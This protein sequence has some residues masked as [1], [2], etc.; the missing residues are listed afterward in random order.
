[1]VMEAGNH[2]R[3]SG[4]RT[5]MRD[6]WKKARDLKVLPGSRF[7]A[8]NVPYLLWPDLLA[9]FGVDYEYHTAEGEIIGNLRGILIEGQVDEA[10]SPGRYA[11]FW[12]DSRDLPRE[13]RSADWILLNDTTFDVERPDATLYD[14]IRL[15]IRRSGQGWDEGGG[16][17]RRSSLWK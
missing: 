12:V 14:L 9:E 8:E 4:S 13:P 2:S 7:S 1:M 6:R 10:V 16:P 15:V 3:H 17:M 5:R 11:R